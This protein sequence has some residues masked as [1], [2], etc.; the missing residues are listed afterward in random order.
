MN[1]AVYAVPVDGTLGKITMYQSES[2]YNTLLIN[3]GQNIEIDLNG[4]ESYSNHRTSINNKGTLKITD[5]SADNVGRLAKGTSTWE[6]TLKVINNTG[7]LIIENIVIYAD[8]KISGIKSGGMHGIFNDGTGNVNIGNVTIDINNNWFAKGISNTSTGILEISVCNIISDEYGL[9]IS[10]PNAKVIINDGEFKGKMFGISI[11]SGMSINNSGTYE[12]GKVNIPEKTHIGYRIED[13]YIVNY[14]EDGAVACTLEV[15]GVITNY[16]SIYEAVAAAPTDG[17][18]AKIT[19]CENEA[20]IRTIEILEGQNIEID[21]DG[22]KLYSQILLKVINNNGNIA[23]SDTSEEQTGEIEV[24]KPTTGQVTIYVI[25]NEGTGTVEYKGGKIN[26]YIE[27]YSPIYGIWNNSTGTIKMSGGKIYIKTTH[28]RNGIRN[29]SNGFVEMTGGE[30]NLYDYNQAGCEGIANLSDGKIKID[31]GKISVSSTGRG[32][33]NS[34]TGTIEINGGE[35]ITTRYEAIYNESTGSIIINDGL[36]KSTESKVINNRSTGP[37]TINGGIISGRGDNNGIISFSNI[38]SEFKINGGKLIKTNTSNTVMFPSTKFV[39]LPENTYLKISYVQSGDS[40]VYVGELDQAGD[41]ELTVSGVG[42]S[43][44]NTLQ[45]AFNAAPT[46]GTFSKIK[47]LTDCELSSDVYITSGKYVQLDLNGHSIKYYATTKEIKAFV[48]NSGQTF[49]IVDT[50]GDGIIDVKAEGYNATAVNNNS[51]SGRIR[52]ISG[53]IQVKSIGKDAYGIYNHNGL[54]NTLGDEAIKVEGGN[55]SV[56]SEIGADTTVSGKAYGIYNRQYGGIAIT[57]K[58]TTINSTSTLNDSYGIYNADTSAA[59]IYVTIGKKDDVASLSSPY[60]A[61]ETYGLYINK[62]GRISL[63]DGAITGNVGG[64]LKTSTSSDATAIIS[65]IEQN[66]FVYTKDNNDG[67]ETVTL[68][69]NIQ[70][71]EVKPDEILSNNLSTDYTLDIS[72]MPVDAADVKLQVESSDVNIAVVNELDKGVYSVRTK[73][74]GSGEITITATDLSNKTLTQTVKLLVDTVAPTTTAPTATSTGSSV[75]I[76]CNQEDEN[77]DKN[78]IYYAISED[79]VTWSSWSK[80]ATINGLKADTLYKI[81]TKASDLLGNTA[82]SEIS[83]IRTKLANNS[84]FTFNPDTM[85]KENVIVTI[86]WNNPQKTPQYYK[87]GDGEWTLETNETTQVTVEENGTTIYTKLIYDGTEESDIKSAT[88]D[89]IDRLAPTGTL[90]INEAYPRYD[91]YVTLKITGTDDASTVGDGLGTIA[92]MYITEENLSEAPA[93]DDE[94]WIKYEGDYD[95]YD[96][97]IQKGEGEVS[98]YVW[99]MDKAHN[100]SNALVATTEFIPPVAVLFEDD[101]LVGEYQSIAEAYNAAR[102]GNINP[103]TII[104][105]QDNTMTAKLTIAANKNIILDLN[106]KHTTASINL[107]IAN[108]GNLEITDGKNGG[109]FTNENASDHTIRNYKNLKIS[110]G[111]IEGIN[112]LSNSNNGFTI[113]NDGK[114][115]MTGGKIYSKKKGTTSSTNFGA[116][117]LINNSTYSD[118]PAVKITGGIVEALGVEN[119]CAYGI[120]NERTSEVLITGGIIK[121]VSEKREGYAIHALNNNNTVTIGVDDGVIRDEQVSIYGSTYGLYRSTGKFNFYDGTIKGADGKSIYCDFANI[122]TPA[123]YGIIKTTADGIET[124][125]LSLDSSA[126]TIGSIEIT[127]DLNVYKQTISAKNVEDFGFGIVAYRFS[128]S[129]TV[130]TKANTDWTYIEATNGPI[131]FSYEVTKNGEYY[132]W[133]MDMA[134]NISN[135]ASVTA[136]NIKIKVTGVTASNINAEVGAE[137]QITVTLSPTGSEAANIIYKATDE[138]IVHVNTETGVVTGLK[139]GNTEITVTAVNYDGTSV[140]GTLTVTV[141]D[142]NKEPVESTRTAPTLVAG[143]KK[144]T[145]TCNQTGENITNTYYAISSDGENYLAWQESNVFENVETGKVYYVKT[146]IV[147]ADGET[148]S[149]AA[150]IAV[151]T[152]TAKLE[153]DGT[154]TYYKD[155]QEAIN[156]ANVSSAKITMLENEIRAAEITV[157][158]G[159][160]VV[161]DLDGHEINILGTSSSKLY[162]VTNKGTIKITDSKETGKLLVSSTNAEAVYGIYNDGGTIELGKI[163]IEVAKTNGAETSYAIYNNS[164]ITTVGDNITAVSTSKPK[165]TSTGYGLYSVSG[166]L[167]YYDGVIIAEKGKTTNGTINLVSGYKITTENLGTQD[168]SYLTELKVDLSTAMIMEWQVP[169][170]TEITLPI[171]NGE[172]VDIVVDYGDGNVEWV[173]GKTFPKHTYQTAGTYQIKISGTLSDFGN[174]SESEITAGS[175]YYTFANYMKKLSKWG[176]LR[177]IKIWLCKL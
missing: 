105:C 96:Y 98:I 35:I 39:E 71:L 171:S 65:N 29:N 114:F 16:L 124:A 137:T 167:N 143:Y 120:R 168:K 37:I 101:V 51:S 40:Y 33:K 165:L 117:A 100:I 10:E 9:Y 111:T 6:N 123:Q 45:Q 95:A 133:A 42:T 108:N 75:T 32:I 11:P 170:N 113:Y 85:T 153:Q 58:N 41:Y 144:I 131:D 138:T 109:V 80:R 129:M 118:G 56:K 12:S 157:A 36:I 155:V 76:T 91:G 119:T 156:N 70:S 162:G 102:T 116:F 48:N 81:K 140:T 83:E 88:V 62:A 172:N 151:P 154:V 148:E 82:E 146:K 7:N 126:P 73:A 107:A 169:A 59:T 49:E 104:V 145:A 106:G 173:K 158:S 147:T 79:G 74:C 47:L 84:K 97:Y 86:T 21:L 103:S 141:T 166:T 20:L 18:F 50:S 94:G 64:A 52:I 149:V 34:G 93:E 125:K 55:I 3:E 57:G 19:M 46:D 175:N 174:Y 115:E 121:A 15:D 164:G 142:P 139:E 161:L 43:Y 77:I 132:F 8:T 99:L 134:G 177:S 38:S 127:N 112:T 159:K 130:P 24:T 136:E 87:V 26:A 163:E 28:W 25:Y 60:I 152:Y 110:G 31:G 23:I 63:Y 72:Y 176:E 78:E 13:E 2:L 22:K 135:T 68:L 67:T 53:K 92:Y 69:K 44:Y 27:S 1:D 160:N 30:I 89:N 150:I 90:A 17:T 122:N 61:G 4:K 54:S 66:T 5:S 128:N 14:L